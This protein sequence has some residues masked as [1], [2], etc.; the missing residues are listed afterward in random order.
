MG[1]VIIVAPLLQFLYYKKKL[2][3]LLKVNYGYSVGFVTNLQD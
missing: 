2:G 1:F 3:K